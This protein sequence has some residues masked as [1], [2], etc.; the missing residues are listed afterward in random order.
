MTSPSPTPRSRRTKGSQR[1]SIE[2]VARL[3]K[4]SS[5]TVS[6]ALRGLPNVSEKTRAKVAAA[7]EQ[8]QYLSLIHI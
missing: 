3:A 5:G 6:R 1:A 4:V 8:L 2:D 7:A